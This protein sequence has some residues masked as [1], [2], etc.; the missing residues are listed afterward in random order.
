MPAEDIIVD[1]AFTLEQALKQRQE[2]PVPEEILERQRIVEVLY[3]S[4]DD[5]L[6]KGQIVVDTSLAVDVKGAFDL[7]KR[8]KFPV[9]SVIPIVDK[10]FL[11]D[12]EKSMSLNNSSG[13]NYRMIA[14]TN[15][16]S[17]HA[18]GRAIDINPAI[19]PYIREDYRY[20]E[21]VEYDSNLPGAM[22]ADGKVVKYFKMHGWAWGGD[23]TDTKD[24]MH[25]E[26]PI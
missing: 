8:I 6:H 5:K 15:K 21:G 12:D 23:W 26:K 19:N 20:P 13:F 18:F 25:F 2:L 7:I 9:Y 1:S 16:L 11:Y 22:T 4:F 14:K 17:N 24:Y 10:L 3:Y